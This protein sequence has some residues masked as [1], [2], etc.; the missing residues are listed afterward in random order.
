MIPGENF[1]FKSF[2]PKI[3]DKEEESAAHMGIAMTHIVFS[4][5]DIGGVL[6]IFDPSSKRTPPLTPSIM[7]MVR[8]ID[9]VS[10]K[11][12]FAPS[13]VKKGPMNPRETL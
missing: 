4:S 1:S 11:K 13:A 6:K 3:F 8:C 9:K 12:I 7:D 2:F 10:F 5:M